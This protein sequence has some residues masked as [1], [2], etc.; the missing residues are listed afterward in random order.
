MRPLN[1]LAITAVAVLALPACT[2]SERSFE[3]QRQEVAA[4]PVMKRRYVDGCIDAVSRKRRADRETIA[5]VMKV[6]PSRV[7]VTFCQR[8]INAL[9]SGRL[10]YADYKTVMEGGDGDISR[11]IAI[12]QG[13]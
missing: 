10:T 2:M 8:A 6:P 9:A 12:L 1:S 4:D 13:R 7:G 3:R 11:V 5:A